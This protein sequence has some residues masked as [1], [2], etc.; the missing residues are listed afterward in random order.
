MAYIP[1]F[2]ITSRIFSLSQSISHALG[3]LEGE[4]L[5]ME[6]VKLRR[7]NSIRTIQSSLAIE[8]NTLSLEQVTHIFEGK[9]VIG[10]QK[11]ILEVQ[12]ALRLYEKFD[13]LNP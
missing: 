5:D 4:K 8:G 6:P 7:E 1:P 2:T 10:P 11:D 3:V 12:N 13:K 9:R